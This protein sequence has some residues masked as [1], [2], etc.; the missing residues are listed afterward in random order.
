MENLWAKR[1]IEKSGEMEIYQDLAN[2]IL[3]YAGGVENVEKSSLTFKD[4]VDLKEIKER[5]R[6]K[7]IAPILHHKAKKEEKEEVGDA[8]LLYGPPGCGKTYITRAILGET[9]VPFFNVRVSDV[10]LEKGG[11][12]KIQET[13]HLA[14]AR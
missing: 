9:E 4:V 3:K 11:E 6:K 10:T 5:M 14:I 12:K 7:V 8:I 13:I 2:Y 1:E